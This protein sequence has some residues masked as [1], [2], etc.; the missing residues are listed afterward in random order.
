[1]HLFELKFLFLLN[2]FYLFFFLNRE[3]PNPHLRAVLREFSGSSKRNEN[4]VFAWMKIEEKALLTLKFHLF[5]LFQ[6]I[7]LHCSI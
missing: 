7:N 4:I 2:H 3:G 5:S 6:Q 1:M